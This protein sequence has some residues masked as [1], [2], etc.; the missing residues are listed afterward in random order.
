MDKKE[1]ILKLL[2]A[3]TE[4]WPLARGLKILIADNVLDENT[5][6]G[7]VDIFAKAIDEVQDTTIQ[8]KLQKSKDFLE[9]LEQ[10]ETE[11]HLRDQKSLDELDEMIK[12]I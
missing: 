3:L 11:Q 2:D 1:Y 7:L 4:Y 6:D 8:K 10:M 12:N 5:I 9:K